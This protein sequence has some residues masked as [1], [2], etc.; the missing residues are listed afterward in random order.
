[1]T[2]LIAASTIGL[3]AANRIVAA[4]VKQAACLGVAVC[5]A[6]ADRAG[7]LLAYGR[8]DGAPL[9]SGQIAQDKAYTVAA[10]GLPTHEW[11]DLIK[12]EPP[13]LH[14]IVKTDRLV[15]FG[16]GVPVEVAGE[17]VGTVGVS[18]GSAEQDRIIA[19][20]GAAALPATE[21]TR[22]D[23]CSVVRHWPRLPLPGR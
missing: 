19:T 5:V 4:A 20:A 22:R 3:D 11:Y 10:F 23:E 17:L 18:G 12:D 21:P 15:V 16:G 6:V 8:M 9:L 2:D 7:H 14:G 13:L 1:M